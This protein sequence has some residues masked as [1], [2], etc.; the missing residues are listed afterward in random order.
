[1]ADWP[2]GTPE[3]RAIAIT[4]L[5]GTWLNTLPFL[6]PYAFGLHTGIDA[7]NNKPT[8][9]T[10]KGAPLYAVA[11]GVVTFSGIGEGKSWGWIVI[12]DCGS[13]ICRYAHVNHFN[14]PVKMVGDRVK[15][16]DVIAHIGNADGYYGEGHHLH[17]DITTT[18]ILLRYPSDWPGSDK[19]RLLLSYAD[20]I[21]YIIDRKDTS[22]MPDP[23]PDPILSYAMTTYRLRL[24][25]HASV[26][27]PYSTIVD[28]YKVVTIKN[29]DP[30]KQYNAV[31]DGGYLATEYLLPVHK[32]PAV[33]KVTTSLNARSAPVVSATNIVLRLKPDAPIDVWQGS[34][35]NDFIQMANGLGFPL[36]VATEWIAI[37]L[38]NIP[39]IDNI[40][41][42]SGGSQTVVDAAFVLANTSAVFIRAGIGSWVD[43]DYERLKRLLDKGRIG[44][45]WQQ[46]ADDDPAL[47]ATLFEETVRA[48]QNPGERIIMAIGYETMNVANGNTATVTQVEA[49]E[50]AIHR[51]TS[52]RPMIYT[53]TSMMPP[54]RASTLSLNQL[55]VS[56]QQIPPVLPPQWR[57]K[58]GKP[59]PGQPAI[60]QYKQRPAPGII[61]QAA[62]GVVDYNRTELTQAGLDKFWLEYGIEYVAPPDEPVL[63]NYYITASPHLNVRSGND[64]SFS[65]IGDIP[66]G[67]MVQV[68]SGF[69][70][71]DFVKLVGQPG[72]VSSKYLSLTKPPPLTPGGPPA[73]AWFPSAYDRGLHLDAGGWPMTGADIALLK[74]NHIK[75]VVLLTQ[76]PSTAA[77]NIAAIKAAGVTSVVLRASLS[78]E[79][80]TAQDYIAQTIPM[81]RV[82][83]DQLGAFKPIMVQIHNEPNLFR[84]GQGKVWQNGTEFGLWWIAVAK[85]YRNAF[86]AA[87]LGF[88]PIP[89]VIDPSVGVEHT[90]FLREAIA[91][92]ALAYADFAAVHSYWAKEDGSDINPPFAEWRTAFGNLPLIG[93]EVSGGNLIR[94]TS[95]AIEKAYKLFVAAGVPMCSW[96]LS[97]PYPNDDF[98]NSRW[99]THD[100]QLGPPLTPPVTTPTPVPAPVSPPRYVP[101]LKPLNQTRIG[102][103]VGSDPDKFKLTGMLQR[104]MATGKPLAGVTVIVDHEYANELAEYTTVMYRMVYGEGAKDEPYNKVSYEGLD[105]V[106]AE[107]AGAAFYHGVV[108]QFIMK[109]NKA[110]Y[111]KLVN[112]CQY[113]PLDGAFNLGCMKEANKEGYKL[114]IFGDSQSSVSEAQWSTRWEALRYA[115]RHGHAAT[116]NAYGP[117]VNDAP[118]GL[119]VSG[120]WGFTWYGGWP[121]RLYNSAPL[122]CRP[123]LIIGETGPSDS[124]ITRDVDY[125]IGDMKAYDL[126]TRL[127]YLL[128]WS[129]WTAGHW[130]GKNI[131]LDFALP[132]IE[133]LVAAT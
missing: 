45:Y 60:Q 61:S 90:K 33:V 129:Y 42:I 41:D 59:L 8:H 5:P 102:L 111:H 17:F 26:Y 88:A 96:L 25:D 69:T 132:D 51:S 55:W 89:S 21:R 16:G 30:N 127:P 85:A 6:T 15:Q 56:S 81:V 50:S 58:D 54:D 87:K 130:I 83:I 72:Y 20:P 84:E 31:Q 27:A 75:T 86:P 36:W 66:Y 108:H 113:H 11:D 114:A 34:Q 37:T 133:A 44:A 124:S 32:L 40:I 1:M 78:D 118:S 52:K 53:R 57:G 65:D 63:T 115:M 121:E 2:V 100:P 23:I 28:Q 131:S 48:S 116:V 101:I 104:L 10:D 123:P 49:M 106:S 109:A 43:P 38:P 80:R 103:H 22:P 67:V 4:K 125:Y 68:F 93:T 70:Q 18:D 120:D 107:A 39:V 35:T 98:V 24:R 46:N 110:H 92:G 47:H 128:F 99:D 95:A 82:Y 14:Y 7:N 94:S 91:T 79:A 112:E 9:N 105:A 29:Y 3:E 76:E 62:G 13:F 71:G 117:Y 122:D 64:V 77:A 97:S 73:P 119:P 19:E 126:K 74:H 12:L